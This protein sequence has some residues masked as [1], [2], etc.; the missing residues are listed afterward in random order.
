MKQ[1]LKEEQLFQQVDPQE[2]GNNEEEVGQRGEGGARKRGLETDQEDKHVMLGD[3]DDPHIV[4]DINEE[5]EEVKQE[6]EHEV[7]EFIER[8]REARGEDTEREAEEEG[9]REGE[10]RKVREL[11]AMT[12]KS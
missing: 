7:E 12:D 5:K 1:T 11:K 9:V 3:M 2:F 8:D 6:R 10:V 4:E